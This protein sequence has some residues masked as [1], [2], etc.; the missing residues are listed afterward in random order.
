MNQEQFEK[1]VEE[2]RKETEPDDPIGEFGNLKANQ[3]YEEN[4][5]RFLEMLNTG[6][7]RP[8]LQDLDLRASV[9]WNRTSIEMR[10]RAE[11]RNE[12]PNQREDFLAY[13]GAVGAIDN[14]AKEIARDYVLND[15]KFMDYQTE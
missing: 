15:M 10:C 13:V 7:L 3:M 6:T 2:L 8:Y 11:E 14:Q 1:A 9:L 5:F 4:R 12:L